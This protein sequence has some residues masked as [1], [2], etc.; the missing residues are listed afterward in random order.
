M[1]AILRRVAVL[2]FSATEAE[3]GESDTAVGA[4]LIAIAV[5]PLKGLDH[6]SFPGR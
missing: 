3:A 2:V 4:A 6:P 5:R 1:S